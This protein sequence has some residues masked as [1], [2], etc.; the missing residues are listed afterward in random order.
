MA[1]LLALPNV[2]ATLRI[3]NQENTSVTGYQKTLEVRNCWMLE[4]MYVRKCW[5][6]E[7]LDVRNAGC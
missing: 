3:V 1:F 7:L 5:M 6:L 4:I 2:V